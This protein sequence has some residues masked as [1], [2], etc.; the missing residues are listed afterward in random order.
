M[1][2]RDLDSELEAC[3]LEQIAQMQ[4]RIIGQERQLQDLAQQQECIADLVQEGKVPPGL[5]VPPGLPHPSHLLEDTSTAFGSVSESLQLTPRTNDTDEL[6]VPSIEWSAKL[7]SSCE[8]LK[9]A[10]DENDENNDENDETRM[11]GRNRPNRHR[12]SGRARQREKKRILKSEAP[13]RSE[14]I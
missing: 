10:N 7:E 13:P 12:A 9:R 3:A 8:K 14:T 2:R 11:L 5:R 1:C 6:Q 4:T